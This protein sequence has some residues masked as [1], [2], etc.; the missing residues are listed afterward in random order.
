M[1]VPKKSFIQKIKSVHPARIIVSSFLFAIIIGTI[2]LSMPICTKDRTHTNILDSLFTVTSCICV[3]GLSTFDVWSHWSLFGQAVILC[4][5]QVG[6]LSLVVFASGFTL[7]MRRKLD[8]REMVIVKEFTHGNTVDLLRLIR[9]ILF[10]AFTCEFIGATILMIRFV[11]A[12]GRQGIWASIFLAVSAY[13]NCGFDVLGFISPNSSLVPFVGDHLVLITISTLVIIGGLG[14]IVIS[15]IYSFFLKKKKHEELHVHLMLHSKVVLIASAVLLLLGSTLFFILEYNNTLDNMNFFDK[16]SSCF[17]YSANCRSGG[18]YCIDQ[19]KTLDSTKIL[20]IVLM[21]IG[22][23]PSSTGG[24]IKTTTFVV[25]VYTTIGVLKGRNDTVILNR[26][27]DKSVVYRSITI[28]NLTMLLLIFTTIVV[29]ST[30]EAK[31]ITAIDAIFESV[32]VC[33][34]TALSSKTTD[35]LSS[36]SML[37]LCITM[38]VGR[39]G[40]L[41]LMSSIISKD[42]NNKQNSYI[43]PEGKIIVE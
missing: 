39:V 8:F 18:F 20:T 42:K 35:Y 22:A 29:L 5:I 37:A 14:F 43:L 36:V 31:S 21:F 41:S 7:L 9:T 4:L 26:R 27:I 40:P 6:G 3:T 25:L 23:S 16:L 15:D 11:P 32:S 12:Y 33:G 34:N 28:I 10:F 2:I 38:F 24:G 1:Q 19:T 17:F 30:N 13:C